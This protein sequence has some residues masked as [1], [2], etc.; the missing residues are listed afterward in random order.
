[1]AAEL[2]YTVE[3]FTSWQT[4]CRHLATPFRVHVPA[5]SDTQLGGVSHVIT[6]ELNRC[7][8]SLGVLT[9]GRLKCTGTNRCLFQLCPRVERTRIHTNITIVESM[10]GLDLRQSN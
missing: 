7:K 5:L 3:Y 1:M 8:T 4:S 6:T 2:V 9:N 10:R